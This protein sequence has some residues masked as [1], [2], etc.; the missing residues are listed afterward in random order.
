MNRPILILTIGYIIGII[1]G[2]YFNVSIVLFYAI[3]LL[4]YYEITKKRK[5]KNKFK[6]FSI[7]RYFRYIKLF[8]KIKTIFIIII[9]SFISNNIVKYLNQKYENLYS[10]VK[11]IQIEGLIISNKEEQEYTNRYK[12][13]VSDSKYKNTNL[14]I[15]T[16]KEINLE[17]GDKIIVSGEF[18]EPQSQRNYKG[19]DY[20]QYLKTL[21][22]YGTIK[23][24]NIEIKEKDCGNSINLL[25]NKAFLEIKE[26]IEQ[27]YNKEI[28]SVILGV[29]LG[30]TDNIDEELKEQFSESNISHVLAISGM[31]IVYIIIISKKI[32]LYNSKFDI[33][34]LYVYNRIFYI[35]SKSWDNGNYNLYEL[36]CL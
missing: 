15:K 35:N 1:W 30:Y 13:K 7:K 33:N 16:N 26:N 27:T 19:F 2:L 20:K 34:N 29:M 36:C 17:Y 32:M 18:Q 4:L 25:S 12:I 31:H 21:K 14:Y 5:R 23:V 11:S 24:D 9:S 22:I 10:N 28:S 6:M 3:I 8:F